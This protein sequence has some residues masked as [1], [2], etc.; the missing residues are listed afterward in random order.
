MSEREYD[1]LVYELYYYASQE[2]YIL[3]IIGEKND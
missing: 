3:T 1:E 2:E